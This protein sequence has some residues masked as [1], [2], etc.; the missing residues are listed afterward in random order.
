[1]ELE[2]LMP[3]RKAAPSNETLVRAA[4]FKIFHLQE[5]VAHVLY[6]AV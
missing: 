1:L 6:L 2:V 4:Y 5:V 3:E